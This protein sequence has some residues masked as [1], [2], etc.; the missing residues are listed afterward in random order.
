MQGSSAIAQVRAQQKR[1][2]DPEGDTGPLSHRPSMVTRLRPYTS[3]YLPPGESVLPMLGIQT[4]GIQHSQSLPRDGTDMAQA[5]ASVA[6][7]T[8]PF[9]L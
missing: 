1:A 2:E 4:S 7:H 5:E 3:L 6:L 9:Q 8:F